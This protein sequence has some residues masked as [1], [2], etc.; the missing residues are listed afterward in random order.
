VLG[1]RREIGTQ[2]R[3]VEPAC[4]FGLAGFAPALDLGGAEVGH[5]DEVAGAAG[6]RQALL[7]VGPEPRAVEH[8]GR[9][10]AVVAERGNG[11]RGS[12]SGHGGPGRLPFDSVQADP[13]KQ[14]WHPVPPL[15][16]RAF[17]AIDL[18]TAQGVVPR[19]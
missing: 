4:A 13:P 9:H 10:Q 2:G 15:A 3:Q 8:A 6:W 5:D 14:Y 19:S 16:R 18:I 17:P 11:G 7:D 12:P 1:A